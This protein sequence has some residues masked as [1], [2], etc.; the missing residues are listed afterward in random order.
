[1][2]APDYAGAGYLFRSSRL[3]WAEGL[4]LELPLLIRHHAA[5]R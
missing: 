4:V 5:A 1:M 3:L 2:P